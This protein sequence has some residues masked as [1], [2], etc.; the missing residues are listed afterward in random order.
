[1]PNSRP[2][3][4]RRG[5]HRLSRRAVLRGGVV[6]LGT[7]PLAG[8]LSACRPPTE[9]TDGAAQGGAPDDTATATTPAT[10]REG[11][12]LVF[13]LEALQAVADPGIFTSLGDWMMLDCIARGLVAVD[14]ATQEVV[15]ELAESWQVSDDGLR[16][17]FT[18]REG[19]T[20][21]DG[22]ELT[23]ESCLPSFRRL[24]DE[25]DPTRP[26]GTYTISEL[27]GENL[28]EVT[29]PDARTLEFVLAERDV[30]FLDRLTH[31]A[32]AILS[33]TALDEHGSDIGTNPVGAGPF[34]FVS[35]TA[36]DRAVLEPFDGYWA[37]KPPVDQLTL[38]VLPDPSAL[39]SALQ[40]QSISASNFVPPSNVDGLNANPELQY[41]E[42]APLTDIF[43]VINAGVSP[44]DDLR[45]RQA[46]NFAID[47]EA[48]VNEAFFGYA[49]QP[50]GLIPPQTLGHD[51]S[52]SELSRRDIDRARELIA[53][54][55]AEGAE[56][57]FVNQNILFWPR[58]GQIVEQNLQEIGLRPQA[59]YVDTATFSERMFDPE[60]HDLA[61]W[62]RAA[63]VP[64]P[65]NKLSPLLVS[66]SGVTQTVTQNHLLD[67]QA[68][69]DGM[70][71]EARQEADEQARDALYQQIDR[72]LLEEVQVYPMLAYTAAPV[73]AQADLINVKPDALGTFRMQLEETGFTA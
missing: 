46:I 47:R 24:M 70:L 11:G 42:A 8:L 64:D 60:G 19:L 73:V 14:Y 25:D 35:A 21:H 52:L 12:D 34:T 68:Q 27:G 32:G 58:I 66:S 67:T 1:M 63:F 44:L 71:D 30:T 45:V 4:W 53:E 5:Q 2:E 17:T 43:L 9:P 50:A 18:L 39:V 51:E 61:V 72:F 54:A 15:P 31:Q 22:T 41:H 38:Q 28:L 33:P 20:F 6:G 57:R 56:V 59:E 62:Q 49:Q 40:N 65:D 36:G 13:G 55:G 16:Y 37:G 7:L 3:E 23:A 10:I 26:E 29:A 48:I 69:L